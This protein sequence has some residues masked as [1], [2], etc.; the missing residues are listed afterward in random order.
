[1]GAPIVDEGSGAG[2]FYVVLVLAGDDVGGEL[3][4]EIAGVAVTFVDEALKDGFE[5][6]DGVGDLGD[7]GRAV[8]ELNEE[9]F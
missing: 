1:M 7:W 6:V 9:G 3:A 2:D 8:L 4:L 5:L